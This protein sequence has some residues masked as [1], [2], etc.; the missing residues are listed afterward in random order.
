MK[1]QKKFCHLCGA[2]MPFGEVCFS[3]G[4][5]AVCCDCADGITVEDLLHVTGTRGT[6]AMLAALGFEK[7]VMI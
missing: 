2:A 5:R 1:N 4:A 6:R 3:F 7:E